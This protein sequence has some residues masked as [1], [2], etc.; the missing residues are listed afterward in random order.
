MRSV[1]PKIKNMNSCFAIV[2]MIAIILVVWF[3]IFNRF[4][5]TNGFARYASNKLHNFQCKKVPM[6]I[7]RKR[8]DALK[9]DSLLQVR[10]SFG[11][12]GNHKRNG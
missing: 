12:K 9:I 8:A 10:I 11:E 1:L 4:L 6:I 2:V 3:L 7:S 5:K